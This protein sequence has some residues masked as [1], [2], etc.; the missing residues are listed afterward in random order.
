M[1]NVVFVFVTVVFQVR[2][3]ILHTVAKRPR[4]TTTVNARTKHNNVRVAKAT[5][6]T[7]AKKITVAKML[8]A[9]AMV[10]VILIL[11]HA[12]VKLVGLVNF[13]SNQVVGQR[14]IVRDMASVFKR[15]TPFNVIAWMV[16][17]PWIAILNPTPSYPKKK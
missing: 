6:V 8:G 13:V 17:K 5:V 1:R 14:V 2:D 16:L 7:L 3:A 4:A 15:A 12:N 9:A 11:K 10:S